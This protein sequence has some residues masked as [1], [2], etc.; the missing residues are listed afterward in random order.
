MKALYRNHGASGTA[1]ISQ[2]QVDLSEI[3]ATRDADMRYVGQEHAVTVELPIAL[4]DNAD[5]AG[6][7]AAST[8]CMRR[9]TATASPAENAEIVSLRSAVTGVMSEAAA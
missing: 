8:P 1:G 9:A 7:K 3:V 5:R 6:I 2:R 4:F